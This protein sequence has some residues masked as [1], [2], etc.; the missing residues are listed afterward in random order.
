MTGRVKKLIYR[1]KKERRILKKYLISKFD[2]GD[3]HGVQDA[4]SDL[5]DVEAALDI[6]ALIKRENDSKSKTRT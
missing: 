6:Y 5:R 2:A 4:A 1:L 3:W